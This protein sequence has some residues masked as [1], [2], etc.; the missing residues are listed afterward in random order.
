MKRWIIA[1][2]LVMLCMINKQAVLAQNHSTNA[3]HIYKNN[4]E[5]GEMIF[6]TS[7][8]GIYAF[9]VMEPKM[10]DIHI[11]L[12][13]KED[14]ID[15][16]T[17]NAIDWYSEQIL[18]FKQCKVMLES[19]HQPIQV[20][21]V[22]DSAQLMTELSYSYIDNKIIFD[23][24]QPGIYGVI[25]DSKSANQ[26][27]MSGVNNKYLKP[28]AQDSKLKIIFLVFGTIFCSLVFKYLPRMN[29]TDKLN[30]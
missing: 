28:N 5:N 6:E 11:K 7:M 12:P 1:L 18:D 15:L 23:M 16:Y 9:E 19:N 13:F 4:I 10:N 27:K 21:K 3:T 26:R 25:Y 20:I 2:M 29:W 14:E 22:N 17:I 30:T 24:N 8:N